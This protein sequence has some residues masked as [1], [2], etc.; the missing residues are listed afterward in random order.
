MPE[1]LAEELA[2]PVRAGGRS[3]APLLVIIGVFLIGAAV[4]ASVLLV[5]GSARTRYVSEHEKKA[6]PKEYLDIPTLEIKDIPL[7]VPLVASGAQRKPLTVGVV[8][9]FEPP[10]G[11][12]ADPKMLEKEFIPRVTNLQAEFRHI[13][14]EEMNSKDYAKLS[15]AGVRNQL[16]KTFKGRF[17]EEMKE[18]GLNRYARVDKVLWRDFFWN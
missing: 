3:R 13:V 2:V 16:L 7:S 8:V 5:G 12:P 4:V 1:E 17:D 6:Q 10:E 15:E 11:E 14:I 18:Y 9:R